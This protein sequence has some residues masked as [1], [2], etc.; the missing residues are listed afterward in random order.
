MLDV[1]KR[2]SNKLWVSDA[3][4]KGGRDYGRLLQGPAYGVKRVRRSLRRKR[5][6]RR[7]P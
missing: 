6:N 7:Y 4:R 2:K 5:R 3:M 1:S